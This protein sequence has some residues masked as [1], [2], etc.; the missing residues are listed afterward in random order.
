MLRQEYNG[1]TNWHTYI[2][3]EH[4]LDAIVTA[5]QDG[6]LELFDADGLRDYIVDQYEEHFDFNI[7]HPARLAVEFWRD[8]IY[9]EVDWQQLAEWVRVAVE[10]K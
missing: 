4:E 10:D 5:I 7:G 3:R 9:S 8:A 1:Y 2:T 6:E